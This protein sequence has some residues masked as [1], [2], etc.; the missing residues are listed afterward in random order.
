MK[1][2][3]T[4]IPYPKDCSSTP[5]EWVK[6]LNDAAGLEHFG[7]SKCFYMLRK[8]IKFHKE[9]YVAILTTVGSERPTEAPGPSKLWKTPGD[10]DNARWKEVRGESSDSTIAQ[11]LSRIASGK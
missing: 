5:E 3:S 2:L 9:A 4:H 1:P 6:E 8:T 11:A 10:D 7:A